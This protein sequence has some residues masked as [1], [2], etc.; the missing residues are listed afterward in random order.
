MSGLCVSVAKN[1]TK[2]LRRLLSV[3]VNS[4]IQLEIAKMIKQSPEL[5]IL[6]S[7]STRF[8]FQHLGL[9]KNIA[10]WWYF[11]PVVFRNKPL[12]F[13]DRTSS[14]LRNPPPKVLYQN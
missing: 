5:K 14:L 9:I 10:N 13:G 12:L 8:A 7:Q 6:K 4:S 11:H 1:C 3:R 2:W